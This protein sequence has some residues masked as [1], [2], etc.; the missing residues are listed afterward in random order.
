[1]AARWLLLWLL[2]L[3]PVRLLLARQWLTLLV[4]QPRGREESD[5]EILRDGGITGEPNGAAAYKQ[6][7]P[8]ITPPSFDAPAPT[9]AQAHKVY[10]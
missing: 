5:V 7:S 10:S 9:A 4:R 1:M 8:A 3:M 6:W 2:A